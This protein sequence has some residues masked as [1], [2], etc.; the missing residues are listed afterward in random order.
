MSRHAILFRV[1]ADDQ[2]PH[3]HEE[4]QNAHRHINGLAYSRDF[5]EAVAIARK[6]AKNCQ[7]PFV[8]MAVPIG[9]K[10]RPLCNVWVINA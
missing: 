3:T 10:N 4:W 7:Y 5:N 2:T 6:A 8:V 1:Y 9:G